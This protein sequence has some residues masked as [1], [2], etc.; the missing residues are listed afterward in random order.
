L[1]GLLFLFGVDGPF[2]FSGGID[3]V[4]IRY[5]LPWCVFLDI[6]AEFCYFGMKTTGLFSGSRSFFL[7][8]WF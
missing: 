8:F 5:G 1:E 3:F 4:S 6:R 2:L 7:V